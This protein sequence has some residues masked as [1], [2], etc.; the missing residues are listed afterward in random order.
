MGAAGAERELAAQ[1][2]LLFVLL[3]VSGQLGSDEARLGEADI[4]VG[5]RDPREFLDRID[6]SVGSELSH[7]WDAPGELSV[8]LYAE[9]EL[10]REGLDVALH[11][12]V[13]LLEDQHLFG[14]LHALH[15]EV[16]G[17]RPEGG[18]REQADLFFEAE[19]L[20][21]LLRVEVAGAGGDYEHLRRF[22]ALIFIE[23]A[24]LELGLRVVEP[25]DGR[26]VQEARGAHALPFADLG[27]AVVLF[28]QFAEHD[29]ASAVAD[30]GRDADYHHLAELF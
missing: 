22:R 24:V 1:Q 16:F 29:V 15:D 25:V 14:A 9:A 27:E 28:G 13:D 11:E 23:G 7:A 17:E 4:G 19:P 30:A 6:D 18:Q 3:C 8:E 12:R 2:G 5:E 10:A 20:N 21:G 26:L